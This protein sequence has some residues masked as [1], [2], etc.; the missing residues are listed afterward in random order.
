MK[1]TAFTPIFLL[2][3]LCTITFSHNNI[4]AQETKQFFRS[5]GNA[6][7]LYTIVDSIISSS[8]YENPEAPL[9]VAFTFKIDSL[10]EIHSAHIRMS[11]NLKS[12]KIYTVCDEIE[13]KYRVRFLYEAFENVDR[14]GKYVRCNYLF[15]KPK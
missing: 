4:F 13:S 11:S 8:Y 14:I 10:G 3:I 6:E 7:E 9:K 1:L 12:E 2:Y 15:Q 5:V